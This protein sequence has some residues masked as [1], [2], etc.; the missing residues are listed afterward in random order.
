L[1]EGSNQGGWSNLVSALEERFASEKGTTHGAAEGN[2]RGDQLAR[3][4]GNAA[5]IENI[6]RL[7]TGDDYP[8]WRVR[9]KV[10]LLLKVVSYLRYV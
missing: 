4:L 3:H 5:F 1:D 6:T 10:I 8:L 7:P 9:C 2:I